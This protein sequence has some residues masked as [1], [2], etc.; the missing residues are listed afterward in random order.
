MVVAD[1]FGLM[2]VWNIQ[3]NG[4]SQINL[5]VSVG[6]AVEFCSHV[7]KA[8]TMAIAPT[9][10]ERVKLT[11]V[12]MGS[13]VRRRRTA[14]QPTKIMKPFNT[15]AQFLNADD[16][17]NFLHV[18]PVRLHADQRGGHHGVGLRAVAALR[19]V[20]LPDVPRHH[21]HLRRPRTHLPPRPLKLHWY[22]L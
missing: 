11:L 8:F 22:E 13:V 3:L 17:K 10:V 14:S 18:G 15:T 20:L 2:Y 7:T 16:T 4:V 9:K 12:K 21:A 5:V 1:M 6:I 19:G